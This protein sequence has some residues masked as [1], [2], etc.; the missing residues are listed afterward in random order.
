[1]LEK[2]TCHHPYSNVVASPKQLL[3][4]LKAGCEIK[5]VGQNENP[6]LIRPQFP[7]Y[8]LVAPNLQWE[9][10][11]EPAHVKAL[12]TLELISVVCSVSS[13]EGDCW[14]SKAD[15]SIP[16]INV[17]PEF[18]C[19]CGWQ[20]DSNDLKENGSLTHADTWFECPSCS[21]SVL[22]MVRAQDSVAHN[23]DSAQLG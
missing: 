1:M 9:Y 6:L 18:I 14:M 19:D 7:K 12:E 2:P 23:Q 4:Y 5:Q 21:G 8:Y 15:F 22:N 16:A 3:G 17:F 10:E 13:A 20:G 11:L